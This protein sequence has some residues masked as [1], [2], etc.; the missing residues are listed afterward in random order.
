MQRLDKF[1]HIAVNY[2]H[3]IFTSPYIS[4]YFRIVRVYHFSY[5][6][7]FVIFSHVIREMKIE[8]YV[9]NIQAMSSNLKVEDESLRNEALEGTNYF[10]V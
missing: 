2:F 7:Y 1:I 5:I 3:T 8:I 6:I 10:H 9:M 4:L